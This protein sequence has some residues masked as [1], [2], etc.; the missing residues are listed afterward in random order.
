MSSPC[1]YD[2][3]D[4]SA[5]DLTF[6]FDAAN[7]NYNGEKTNFL[8]LSQNDPITNSFLFFDI[9]ADIECK[10]KV[11]Y[12]EF[13]LLFNKVTGSSNGSNNIFLPEGSFLINT[14]TKRPSA[15][16]P[17]I[18]QTVVNDIIAG[19]GNFLASKGFLVIIYEKAE[20]STVRKV[21]VYFEKC[22]K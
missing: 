21:F 3:P 19:T 6:Y 22:K 2:I 15:T 1:F 5:P 11:G 16:E 7:L 8:V 13:N 4:G 18:E 14:I 17:A 9:Y 12:V 10:E 20:V